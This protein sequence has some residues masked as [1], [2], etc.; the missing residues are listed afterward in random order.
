[1]T[2]DDERKKLPPEPRR[3]PAPERAPHK[4]PAPERHSIPPDRVIKEYD[5]HAED[6]HGEP[7]E[8]EDPDS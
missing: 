6:R 7:T 5:E 1:M 8:D 4:E 2:G 3:E